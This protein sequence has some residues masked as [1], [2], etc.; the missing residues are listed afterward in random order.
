MLV[1]E[2]YVCT[3]MSHFGWN[4]VMD[5]LLLAHPDDCVCMLVLSIVD[6]R[7]GMCDNAGWQCASLFTLCW[8]V[9]INHWRAMPLCHFAGSIPLSRRLV[10]IAQWCLY[11]VHEILCWFVSKKTPNNAVTSVSIIRLQS[12][13]WRQ[14]QCNR[15]MDVWPLFAIFLDYFRDEL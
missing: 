6:A 2:W 3:R 5:L 7:L 8:D 12:I 13:V 9:L 10:W 4:W 11:K 14:N 1:A 15:H